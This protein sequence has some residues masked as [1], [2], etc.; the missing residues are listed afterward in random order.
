MNRFIKERKNNWQRL[1]ELLSTLEKFSLRECQNWK[2]ANS[3]NFTAA[4]RLIWRLP[5]SKRATRK[6][7]I[8]LPSCPFTN[9]SL[10]KSRQLTAIKLSKMTFLFILNLIK[11]PVS[12]SFLTAE[13]VIKQFID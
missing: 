4:P 5:A 9:A 7:L 2:C 12:K 13:Y 11:K 10:K 8:I 3:A 1:E 6:S